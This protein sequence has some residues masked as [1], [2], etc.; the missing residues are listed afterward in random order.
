MEL[1]FQLT[2]KKGFNETESADFKVI[3][4]FYFESNQL[5]LTQ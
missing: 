5:S 2:I 1:P 4:S 3:N